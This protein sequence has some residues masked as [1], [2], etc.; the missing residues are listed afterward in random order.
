MA[1]RGKIRFGVLPLAFCRAAY[2]WILFVISL[3]GIYVV[4]TNTLSLVRTH[5]AAKGDIFGNT[6]IG[7]YSIVWGIAWWMIFRGKPAAH[8]WAIAANMVIIFNYLPALPFEGWRNFLRDEMA[9]RYFALFGVFGIII[10]SIPYHGW[11]H[12]SR[13]TAT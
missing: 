11:R 13:I 7:I 12:K 8:K 10:F 3:A 6:I 5:S 9:W 2:C 1:L 4:C